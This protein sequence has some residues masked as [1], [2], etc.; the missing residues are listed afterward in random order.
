MIR[1]LRF[2][3]VRWRSLVNFRERLLTGTLRGDKRFVKLAN[4]RA[5]EAFNAFLDFNRDRKDNGI[6]RVSGK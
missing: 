5:R 3:P 6:R 1:D 2:Y 4:S